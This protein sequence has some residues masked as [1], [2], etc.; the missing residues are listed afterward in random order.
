M[1]L[2]KIYSGSE[3]E[4]TPVKTALQEAGIDPIVKNNVQSATSAGF[5]TIGQAVELYVEE[6][7][8]EEANAIISRFK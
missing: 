8:A 6:N 5:P 7:E 1:G 3:I 4:V 2:I